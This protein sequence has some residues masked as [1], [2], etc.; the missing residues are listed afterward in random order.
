[1]KTLNAAVL[2]IIFGALLSSCS[3]G[4]PVSSSGDTTPTRSFKMGFTP[5]PYAA[6]VEAV[7]TTYEFLED[8]GDLIAHQ[9]DGGIPWVEALEDDS[10]E[11]YSDNLQSEVEWRVAKTEAMS[12]KTVYVAVSPFSSLRDGMALY[13]GDSTNEALPSPWDTYT[14]DSSYVALAYTNFLTEIIDRLNPTYVN[15]AVEVNEYYGNTTTDAEKEALIDFLS[16]VYSLLKSR[17]PNVYFMTSFTLSTPGSDKMIEAAELYTLIGNYMDLFGISVYP[18]AFFEHE[19]KGDPANLP[20]DWLYQVTEIAPGQSYFVAE[21]G[22]IAE[23]LSIPAYSLSVESDEEKQA[24]YVQELMQQSERLSMYGVVWF[25][26]ID[27]DDLWDSSLG[28]DLSLIWRDTGLYDG[29]LVEREA[30]GV[31]RYWYGFGTSANR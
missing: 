30:F 28:D 8:N 16:T 19:D 21:T 20:Q 1:M 25:A 10:F 14:F 22:F 15:Y 27:F 11:T 24:D 18:Y 9:F 29:D 5:W 7:D 13:W 2:Y 6:T 31:W 23:D 12:G 17:H 3:G 4:D 26:P